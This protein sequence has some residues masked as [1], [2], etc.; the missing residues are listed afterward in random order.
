MYI[1][2]I[3]S[4]E[5]SIFMYVALI[6]IFIADTGT[7]IR[8][9]TQLAKLHTFFLLKGYTSVLLSKATYNLSKSTAEQK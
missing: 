2:V 7:C 6:L 3:F 5:L 4:S 8:V 1:K 9:Q